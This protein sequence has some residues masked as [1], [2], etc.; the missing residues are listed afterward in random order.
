MPTYLATFGF[1]KTAGV[2]MG[3]AIKTV[4]AEAIATFAFAITTS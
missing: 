1:A 2:A 3:F 4:K